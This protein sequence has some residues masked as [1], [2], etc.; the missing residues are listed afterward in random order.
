MTI[1]ILL[2]DDHQVLREGLKAILEKESDLKIAGQAGN[3]QEAVQLCRDLDPDVVL[4][5]INMPKLNGVEATREVTQQ[6]K[7]IGVTILSMYATKEHIYQAF[8]AGARGYLLKETSGLEVVDAIHEVAQGN[9][10]LS[11][12]L[13]EQ[14]IDDYLLV[15]DPE[16]STSPLDSLSE[17]ERQ[18]LGLV[19]EG[20]TSKEIARSLHLSLSTVSTYRS[21]LMKKLGVEDLTELIKFAVEHRLI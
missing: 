11:K 19:A 16:N 21:R 12:A 15:R 18:V 20:K 6:Q 9:R 5:D 4:M 7:E 17:R 2:A 10:F 8:K 13:T 14:M 3:G 1:E